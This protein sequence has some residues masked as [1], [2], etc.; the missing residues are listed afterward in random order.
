MLSLVL[1]GALIFLI[2]SVCFSIIS[3]VRE[4]SKFSANL[5]QRKYTRRGL[6]KHIVPPG[7]SPF[8][9]EDN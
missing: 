8:H 7:F 1:L 2:R 6:I 9:T 3:L 4:L 5:F